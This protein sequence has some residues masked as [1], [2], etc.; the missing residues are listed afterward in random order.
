M[1]YQTITYELNDGMAVVTMNR[2]DKYN[3][4]TTRCVPRS[5]MR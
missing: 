3:A 2:A 4:L 1:D 5:H